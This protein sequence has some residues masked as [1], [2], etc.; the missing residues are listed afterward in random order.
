MARV[1]PKKRREDILRVT[2]FCSRAEYEALKRGERVVNHRDHFQGGKGGSLSKGFCFTEDAPMVAWRYLK[3]VVVAEICLVLDIPKSLLT[4]SSGVYRDWAHSVGN[5]VKRCL[6]D[7]WCT[8]SY[9]LGEGEARLV[10]ALEMYKVISLRELEILPL[11]NAMAA[12]NLAPA[13]DERMSTDK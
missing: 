13:G 4:K 9:K 1:N 5:T 2:R 10:K 12:A 6:K 7:E 11:A 3:G 8:T